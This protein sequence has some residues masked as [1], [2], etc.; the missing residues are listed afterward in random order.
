E[1][2]YN[3]T[4]DESGEGIIGGVDL[5]IHGTHH[6]AT[7]GSQSSFMT[8]CE[9]YVWQARNAISGFLFDRLLFG[10]ENVPVTDYGLLDDFVIPIQ[11]THIID[12]DNIP[13]DRPWHV[14][15]PE[16]VILESSP[17]SA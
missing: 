1:E 12:P 17:A 14:P 13:D 5:S 7:H 10:D 11:E 3:F 6:S 16:N 15:E 9:K 4:K 2:F 8:V